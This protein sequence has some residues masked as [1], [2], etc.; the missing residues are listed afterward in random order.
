[1]LIENIVNIIVL[2]YQD[3]KSCCKEG[4]KQCELLRLR[5]ILST[6]SDASFQHLNI[7]VGIG[8]IED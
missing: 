7:K 1:M 2:Q 3:D 6:T 4:Q 5:A 8:V